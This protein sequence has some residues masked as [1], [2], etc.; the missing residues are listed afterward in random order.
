MTL[1]WPTTSIKYNNSTSIFRINLWLIL[2][3][4]SCW[5]Y[6]IFHLSMYVQHATQKI[7]C[8]VPVS[9][10]WQK[11]ISTSILPTRNMFGAY[12]YHLLTSWWARRKGGS[13]RTAS[14]YITVYITTT[15]GRKSMFA[16]RVDNLIKLRLGWREGGYHEVI[17]LSQH[18]FIAG[19]SSLVSILQ[20]P[21]SQYGN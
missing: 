20:I 5:V 21:L 11:L 14:H 1:L 9:S 8:V 19:S 7:V 10:K 17:I 15:L 2:V 4:M 3:K 6:I 12:I 18:W 13:K 16:C